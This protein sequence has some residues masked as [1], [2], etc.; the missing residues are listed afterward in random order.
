MAT[1]ES[2][3]EISKRMWI[4]LAVLALVR[5]WFLTHEISPR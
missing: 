1:G 3:M 2:A 4:G 5:G